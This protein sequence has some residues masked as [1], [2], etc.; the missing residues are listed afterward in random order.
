MTMEVRHSKGVTSLEFSRYPF[1]G[2]ADS[3]FYVIDSMVDVDSSNLGRPVYLFETRES[4]K[5][6][7]TVIQIADWMA[8]NGADK[9]STI[10]CVGGGVAQDI[11]T[12]LASLYMRGITWLFAPTTT[13][14]VLDSCVGG[15]SAINTSERKNLLGNFYPPQQILVDLSLLGS[16]DTSSYVGGIIEAVKICLVSSPEEFRTISDLVTNNGPVVDQSMVEL[17]LGA[18][19]RIVEADEFDTGPRRLL[20]YGHTFGHALEAATN[21]KVNH[22][23]AVGY[24]ILAAN[25][26]SGYSFPIRAELDSLIRSLLEIVPAGNHPNFGSL[27]WTIFRNAFLNDKKHS[28]GTFNL[29]LANKEG[30]VEI[31]K[32]PT[33]NEVLERV[34]GAMEAALSGR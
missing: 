13:N 33:E 9:N 30:R 10:I 5:T 27:D 7:E 17:A 29:V 16:L 6:L 26:F 31:M 25:V 20:N 32:H 23:I 34:C 4:L 12:L 24:G 15:K 19:I 3:F 14:S 8:D 21:F 28:V 11:C 2:P 22:G 18:K 1:F